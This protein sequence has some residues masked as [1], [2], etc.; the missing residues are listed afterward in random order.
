MALRRE[1][2]RRSVKG[3]HHTAAAEDN[4]AA[5]T[6]LVKGESVSVKALRRAF[7]AHNFAAAPAVVLALR[8]R[9][10]RL[11]AVLAGVDLV[12]WH[13]L[14]LVDALAQLCL[15]RQK[16]STELLHLV[17]SHLRNTVLDRRAGLIQHA[18]AQRLFERLLECKVRWRRRRC[19]RLNWLGQG[20]RKLSGSRGISIRCRYFWRRLLKTWLLLYR[21]CWR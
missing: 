20:C 1:C 9:E 14:S 3:L 18:V 5:R 10:L 17:L 19:L 16:L 4:V 7:L 12:V 2:R 13:P 8:E 21:W 15:P 6:H 11:A